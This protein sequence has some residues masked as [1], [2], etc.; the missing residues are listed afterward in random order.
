M[1][2]ILGVGAGI[3]FAL[4]PHVLRPT[5]DNTNG[6]SRVTGLPVLGAVGRLRRPSDLIQ[7]RQQINRLAIAG[8]L[9]VFVGAVFVLF[10][11]AGARAIQNLLI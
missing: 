4:L 6:L 8:G 10:G 5:F 1:V 11:N 7:T 9:L 2:M 3:A